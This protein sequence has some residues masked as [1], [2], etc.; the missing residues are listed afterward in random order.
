MDVSVCHHPNLTQVLGHQGPSPGL[1]PLTAR[2]P[3]LSAQPALAPILLHSQRRRP[4]SW[5][6]PF[7]PCDRAGDRPARSPVLPVRCRWPPSAPVLAGSLSQCEMT[8]F[9]L[10]AA[11]LSVWRVLCDTPHFGWLESH[12]VQPA[13]WRL[14]LFRGSA[15][16]WMSWCPP[17]SPAPLSGCWVL[18][19]PAGLLKRS[20]AR[21]AE[22]SHP[23][24]ETWVAWAGGLCGQEMGQGAVGPCVPEAL[25]PAPR[26]G[27]AVGGHSVTSPRPPVCRPP[28][29]G[30]AQSR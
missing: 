25:C 8:I 12:T 4:G 2:V 19:R 11:S 16:P 9:P 10:D 27:W 15:L 18:P 7:T 29:L 17:A 6:C 30:R 28:C 14:S 24:L 5:L 22:A 21:E 23:I 26:H 20:E 13:S 3:R 1:A